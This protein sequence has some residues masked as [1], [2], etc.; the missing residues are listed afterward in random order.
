MRDRSQRADRV[1]STARS[2]LRRSCRWTGYQA[3][4]RCTQPSASVLAQKSGSYADYRPLRHAT[5]HG[6]SKSL[7]YRVLVKHRS[8]LAR[9][10]VVGVLS[11]CKVAPALRRR[12]RKLD[13]LALPCK[14][15]E[16]TA[17]KTLF[18]SLCTARI[19]ASGFRSPVSGFRS[20]V[21]GLRSP[22]SGLGV[23]A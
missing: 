8:W 5:L 17:P 18:E 14:R 12:L 7:G 11:V 15:G 20:P 9:S 3:V 16:H 10:N 21:S 13:S 2:P 19:E 23:P 1:S 6:P 4:G 22:V